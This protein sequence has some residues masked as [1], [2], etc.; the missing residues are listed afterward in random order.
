L[1]Y[2]SFIETPA[3]TKLIADLVPDDLYR[4]F[5]DY[6]AEHPDAG[7]LIQGLDGLRKIRLALPGKGKRGGARVIYFWRTAED[8]ILFVLVYAKHS[9]G[10]LTDAQ[11]KILKRIMEVE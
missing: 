10:N 1:A 7:D 6:L 11:K 2:D 3:F 8:Q 9:Q 5:Q 4:E